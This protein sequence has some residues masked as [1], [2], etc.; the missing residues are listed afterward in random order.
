MD[1]DQ[2]LGAAQ[3]L[4]K[5]RTTN[6][7]CQISLEE[8]GEASKR[9]RVSVGSGLWEFEKSSIQAMQLFSP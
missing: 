8:N 2:E 1:A 5:S 7:L 6:I 9:R 4:R 3:V